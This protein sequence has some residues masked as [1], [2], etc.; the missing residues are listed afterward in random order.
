MIAQFDVKYEE[1]EPKDLTIT[2]TIPAYCAGVLFR[3]GVGPLSFDTKNKKNKQYRTNHWFDCLAQ[4]HRFQ[5][6][7]PS[8]GE[9]SIQRIS[10][11]SRRTC[12]GVIK[13][14]QETGNRSGVTFAA[15]YEPCKTFFG[16]VQSMFTSAPSEDYPADL[17]IAVTLSPNFPGFSRTG[18]R[19]EAP[20]NTTGINTLFNK[21]DNFLIQ[22]LDPETLE[23]I[24]LARQTVLHPDLK[25]PCS[26][27]H[28]KVCPKTNDTY[29][30]NLE[31][32][33]TGTYRA[34]HV[35]A[36]TGKCTILATFPAKPA[37]LHSSFL[38]ENYYIVCV[39]NSHF[40]MGG[41][42]I[43]WHKNF[44]D[45]LADFNAQE[46]AKW[47]VVDRKAPEEG[48][49]GLVATFE[50]TPFFCFHAINAY[51]ETRESGQIDII[52]DVC[53]YDNLDVLKRFYVD[54][55]RSDS[56][57]AASYHDP[58]FAS[59]KSYFR[60][61]KLPDLGTAGLSNRKAENVGKGSK[62][63]APEL[64]A[65]NHKYR[66]R[67]YRY[68]YGVTD[69]GKAVFLDGIVKY[70]T[71]NNVPARIWSRHGQSAGEP[72]FI[73]DPTAMEGE[74]DRGVLLSAVLDGAAQ[75]T[76]LLVLDAQELT[77]IGRATMPEGPG[78]VLGFGFHGAHFG[79][80]NG[81]IEACT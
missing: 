58:K 8:K 45:S 49:K 69:T 72:I 50:S 71:V 44:I 52:A 27:A 51:E 9:N 36:S 47:Y 17:N 46:P 62:G 6:H 30:Y 73:P 80:N 21:T 28:A 24:G 26:G 64:P 15:K 48:G 19:Q 43:L 10:H 32:G 63:L 25:G 2:G 70:D 38:T 61:F 57:A 54:N 42:S 1:L 68:V 74:E 77:E 4:V 29:N 66:G 12:D 81:T 55:M 53:A 56:K 35:S 79:L 7:T 3:N 11:N 75:R 33:R 78:G 37:Y 59:S 23:P 22:A 67:K 76:Y 13:S 41:A 65:F 31:F 34:F 39:W 5:L 40:T 60:R 18:E 14:I 20:T 16:K